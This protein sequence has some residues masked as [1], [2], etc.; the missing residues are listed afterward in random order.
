M[1]CYFLGFEDECNRDVSTVASLRTVL[2]CQPPRFRDISGHIME[3]S[4]AHRWGAAGPP[5][6]AYSRV[7]NPERFAS[8]HDSASRFL[9]RLEGEFETERRERRTALIPS[10]STAAIWRARA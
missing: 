1:R 8:L 9:H 7:T 5:P 3:R 10:W 4:G 6:E 2:L